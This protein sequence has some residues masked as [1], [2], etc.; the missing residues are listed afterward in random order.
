MAC[1]Q[2]YVG[3]VLILWLGELDSYMYQTAGHEMIE[4]IAQALCLPLH[5]RKLHGKSV[6]TG[7]DYAEP[8]Q[9]D[10][11]EDLYELMKEVKVGS[12]F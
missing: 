3:C 4:G 9:G 7:A 6:N 10:E 2:M 12:N 11:V 1:I 5:R 8:T